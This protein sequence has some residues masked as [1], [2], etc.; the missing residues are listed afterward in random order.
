MVSFDE[1]KKL[2]LKVGQ[3]KEVKQHPNADKLIVLKVDIGEK[4]IQLVAGIKQYY[5]VEELK[6]KKIVVITNLDSANL[7]GEKS[8]GM[9]LA[10]VDKD[11]VVLVCP[12]KDIGAGAKIQ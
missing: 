5:K 11:K 12:E 7:R 6:D 8:E 10:A 1:W 2:D 4:E 3:I 9:L